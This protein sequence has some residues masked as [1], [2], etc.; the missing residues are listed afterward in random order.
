MNG[1]WSKI[2]QQLCDV[3]NKPIRFIEKEALSGGCISQ[4]WKVIDNSGNTFFI[5]INSPDLE[6]MFIGEAKGLEEIAKSKTIRTPRVYL[7]G[8]TPECSYLVLEYIPLHSHTNQKERGK[9]IAQMHHLTNPLATPSNRFGCQF[10]NH[11]G[12]TPQGNTYKTDWVSFWREE[13]LLTQ[14]DIAKNNGYSITAYDKGLR[15]ADSLN[16]FFTN[17]QPKPSLLHGDLWGG[18]CASDEHGKPVIYDPAVYYGDRETDIAMTEL[19]GGFTKDF[20]IAYNKFYPLDSGYKT[21]KKLYNLYHVLNHFNLFGG[22][23]AGQ[24]DKMTQELLSSVN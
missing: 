14:L 11:I 13:R 9:Q 6:S 10:N 19:F 1:Y 21:R 17:Y 23:Y 22:S 12:S 5:K 8:S 15:L 7:S 24:A 4:S 18:N 3:L 16:C 20:Y 2:E